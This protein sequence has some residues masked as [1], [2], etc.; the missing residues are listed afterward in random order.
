MTRTR[1][2]SFFLQRVSDYKLQQ[3][4]NLRKS[5][6]HE[7]RLFWE[8]VR[9]NRVM[10]LQFRRQQP[11]EGFITDFYC[12]QARCV[13]EIDGSVHDNPERKAM[14]ER[15]RKVFESRGLT[16]IRFT[17]NEIRNDIHGVIERLKKRLELLLTSTPTKSSH[18]SEDL[19]E[20]G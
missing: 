19:Q 2:V 16:E 6:T 15:R 13:V 20:K 4:R 17:N 10:G 11:V 12:N 1:A 3:A 8:R 5:T 14:D 7:E 9:G 18:W